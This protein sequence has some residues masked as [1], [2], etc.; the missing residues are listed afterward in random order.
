MADNLT[1]N[2]DNTK[3]VVAGISSALAAALEEMGLSAEAH[4][5]RA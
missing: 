4:A 5:K 2:E 1:V 3:A